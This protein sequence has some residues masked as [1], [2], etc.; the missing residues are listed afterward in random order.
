[1]LAREVKLLIQLFFRDHDPLARCLL[2]LDQ[3]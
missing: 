2:S 1:V 3:R